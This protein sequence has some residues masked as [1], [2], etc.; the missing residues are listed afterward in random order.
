MLYLDYPH[1]L[2]NLHQGYPLAPQSVKITLD[3]PSEKQQNVLTNVKE[4]L[5]LQILLLN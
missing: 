1:L 2:H 5:N 4:A 3:M